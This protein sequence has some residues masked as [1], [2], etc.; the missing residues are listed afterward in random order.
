MFVR[1]LCELKWVVVSRRRG[2]EKGKGTEGKKE[3]KDGR[4]FSVICKRAVLSV[5][6]FENWWVERRSLFYN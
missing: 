6:G 5:S 3:I 2:G 4:V 1:V